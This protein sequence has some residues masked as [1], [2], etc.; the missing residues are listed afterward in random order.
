MLEGIGIGTG[1]FFSEPAAGGTDE[2]AFQNRLCYSE[3]YSPSCGIASVRGRLRHRDVSRAPQENSGREA[4]VERRLEPSAFGQPWPSVAALIA[5]ELSPTV[6]SG[7]APR[8]EGAFEKA[9]FA[10]KDA[11]RPHLGIS[12]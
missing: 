11:F 3:P 8:G 5:T 10:S 9:I 6:A 2:A 4:Y 7:R 12:A 1:A